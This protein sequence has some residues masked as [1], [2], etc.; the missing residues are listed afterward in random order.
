MSAR[1]QIGLLSAICHWFADHELN[2]E[3]LHASTDGQTAH[4]VFLVTGTCSAQEL[5]ALSQPR[6]L[7]RVLD[8]AGGDARAHE[9]VSVKFCVAERPLPLDAVIVNR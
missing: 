8:R 1:D 3:S 2:V 7:A 6:P 4:D 5:A 9:I